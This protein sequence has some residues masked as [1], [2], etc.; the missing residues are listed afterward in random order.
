MNLDMIVLENIKAASLNAMEEMNNP[1]RCAELL[2]YI[3][4]LACELMTMKRIEQKKQLAGIVAGGI[5]ELKEAAKDLDGCI[6]N[7]PQ[8]VKTFDIQLDSDFPE[9]IDLGNS[10]IAVKVD[11]R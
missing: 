3:N 7:K 6:P 8:S 4:E 9:S 10:L 5:V 2:T 11:K 1:V